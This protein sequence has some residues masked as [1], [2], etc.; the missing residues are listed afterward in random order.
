MIRFQY[1]KTAMQ[2][3]TRELKMRQRALPTLKAKE[4]A[5]RLEIG[6][7]RKQLR[8]LEAELKKLTERNMEFAGLWREYPELLSIANI[9]LRHKNIAGV[10]MPELENIEF[11]TRDYS[12]FANRAWVPGG[13]ELLKEFCLLNLQARLTRDGLSLL[14]Y[15]RKKTTQKVNLYEK[16]QI[17]GFQEAIRRIKRFLEDQENLSRA[18][19]KIVKERNARRDEAEL[20]A[21]NNSAANG[22]N[23]P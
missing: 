9:E 1:N 21:Q 16:V 17:P 8:T 2:A 10:R 14:Q 5:L 20:A 3:L 15:T 7:A 11:T 18:A 22:G 4:T 23:T 13:T 12:P 6:K 19:Q